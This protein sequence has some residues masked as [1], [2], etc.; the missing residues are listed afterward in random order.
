M[1]NR[2]ERSP[3]AD[4]PDAPPA[5]LLPP[6][7]AAAVNLRRRR[8]AFALLVVATMLCLVAAFA[9]ALGGNGLGWIELAML[10]VF[11]ATLPWLVV[12]FWN[13]VIGAAILIADAGDPQRVLPLAKPAGTSPL[14]ARVAIVVPIHEEDPGLVFRHLQTVIASLD[15]TGHG[16]AFDLFVLSDSRNDV[17]AQ[18]EARLFAEWQAQ[19]RLSHRRMHYR[20]R[21][22]NHG[23]KAGNIRDFCDQWG[24][25]YDLMIVLDADSVMTGPALL[26]LVR[27]MQAN[28]ELGI[29]QTL[30]VGLPSSSAF[31]R[32]FQFGM[33]H[34]MRVYTIGSAWWQGDCGPY[35][36]HNAIVRLAPFMAHCRLPDLPGRPPLGGAILSH[37]QIEAVLMRRAGF[38]VRVLPLEDGS[39][40][41][42]P[43]TLPDFIKRDLR[44]CQGNLQYVRLLRMPGL[45]ALSRCQLVLAILMYTNAPCLL[46]L[47]MLGTVRL[48]LGPTAALT[49]PL[50]LSL[51]GEAIAASGIGLA[52]FA[53]IVLISLAPKL[54]G[55]ACALSD[56]R[57]RL[58]FG[59]ARRLLAGSLSELVFSMLLAPTISVAQTLFMAGLIVRHATGWRSQIRTGRVV[60]WAEAFAHLWPQSLLGTAWL[61]SLAV[62][63]PTLLPWAA[64]VIAGLMLAAPLAVFTSRAS[65]GAWLVRSR[66][67]ATPEEVERSV[68]IRSVC[69]WIIP[70]G[71]GA[72]RRRRRA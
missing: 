29:L 7:S 22:D 23:F 17:L 5:S 43:P 35:W 2:D 19:T 60:T 38:H 26:R 67:C 54:C 61:A 16:D 24:Q 55:V 62:V 63:N 30:V 65:V 53:A 58:A 14:S 57:Q 51:G 52:L 8:A 33:R 13:A 70:K 6:Y 71:T 46:T 3:T 66:L 40:E 31:A 34:G 1:S 10:G 11:T 56:R 12:G 50:Q 49:P 69:P 59:G 20:R 42:N 18:H 68:E 32:L 37:D 9:L 44:W 4:Q 21:V 72:S 36:G 27:L 45:P 41:A 64:P 25:D 48:L 28:P 15:A 39:Y 47:L